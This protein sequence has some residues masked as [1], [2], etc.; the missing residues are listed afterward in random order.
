MLKNYI[1]QLLCTEAIRKLILYDVLVLGSFPIR[2]PLG[3]I[4]PLLH[5]LSFSLMCPVQTAPFIPISSIIH[6]CTK[7]EFV[8]KLGSPD[9]VSG[10]KSGVWTSESGLRSLHF[11]V[12]TWCLESALG[13]PTWKS[14]SSHQESRLVVW[15]LSLECEV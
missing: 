10:L 7:Q 4:A 6:Q 3:K 8:V 14:K 11:V 5:R 13:V 15:T 1:K 2:Y 9:L 12:Q